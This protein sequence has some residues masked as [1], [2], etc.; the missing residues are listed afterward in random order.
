MLLLPNKKKVAS[1]IV[2]S[3]S[4]KK[5]DYV[6]KLGEESDTGE[7]KLP[8]SDEDDSKMGLKTV[9]ESIIKAVK[10]DKPEDVV[11]SLK[12]FI[13]MCGHSEDEG[14]EDGDDNGE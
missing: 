2:A 13:Y 8:E 7:Y 1:L 11:K 9:A 4:P 6:Q 10:E 3:M 12:Q 14:T 5:P